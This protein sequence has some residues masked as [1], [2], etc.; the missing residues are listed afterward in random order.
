MFFVCDFCR[1]WREHEVSQWFEA[2][3]AG[4]R[5]A[6][7]RRRGQWNNGLTWLQGAEEGGR[8]CCAL[9]AEHAGPETKQQP[10]PDDKNGRNEHFR[11]FWRH[12]LSSIAF[13]ANPRP[14]GRPGPSGHRTFA[15][16]GR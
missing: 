14:P 2:E 3:T 9:A 7:G 16:P 13:C 4:S 8:A 12:T 11:N 5:Y 10:Q 1:A 15:L 6:D